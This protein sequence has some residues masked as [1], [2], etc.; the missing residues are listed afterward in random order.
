M[1]LSRE[2]SANTK[3]INEAC[4]HILMLKDQMGLLDGL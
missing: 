1:E 3:R 4:R 2:D